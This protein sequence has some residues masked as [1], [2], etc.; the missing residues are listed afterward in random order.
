MP[1]S[2][3]WEQAI[4]QH[5]V[6]KAD[7]ATVP[8]CYMGLTVNTCTKTTPGAEPTNTSYARVELAPADFAT[9]SG[10]SMTTAVD[11]EFPQATDDWASGANFVNVVLWT[12]ST[13]GTASTQYIGFIPLATA[14]T[15]LQNKI[16]KFPAGQLTLVFS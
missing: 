4:L 11:K 9:P 10:S 2:Q 12:V 14:K 1:W 8:A 13:G 6:S 5:G 7:W 15:I 3:T 16:A